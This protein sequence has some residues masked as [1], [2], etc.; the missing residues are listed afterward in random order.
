MKDRI[1]LIFTYLTF[2]SFVLLSLHCLHSKKISIISI[3]Q[4]KHINPNSL[5]YTKVHDPIQLSFERFPIASSEDSTYATPRIPETF[6]LRIPK[7]YIYSDQGYVI[8]NKQFMISELIWPWSPIKKSQACLEN[9]PQAQ[10][11]KGTVLVLA[12]E[13]HHN[14]Y[15]WM[16]EI[17][18]KLALIDQLSY[19]W[20][21]LPRIDLAFQQKTLQCLGI[22]TSKLIQADKNTYIEADELIIPSYVSKS[23]Y[24]PRWVC[25]YLQNKFL[26]LTKNFSEQ[27]FCNKI[28]I[29]R[30]KAPHRRIINEDELFNVLRPLGFQKYYL[31]DLDF[32][33]QVKLFSQAKTIVAAHGAGLTNIIFCKPNTQIIE[34]FQEREDDTFCYLSQTM[35]LNYTCLKTTEFKEGLGYSDTLLP[36]QLFKQ[37]ISN[38]PEKF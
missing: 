35:N 37:F 14:Y 6:I 22:N 32:V 13:G 12:Q 3:E 10:K 4:L 25:D 33:Q 28:F 30:Q 34:L 23:C 24:S 31:E 2:A 21:Y 15:H 20:I 5:H 7:A 8:I 36:I 1:Y 26:P 27:Q 19:D 16:M 9:L 29:S 17:I 18:P 11:L 38:H